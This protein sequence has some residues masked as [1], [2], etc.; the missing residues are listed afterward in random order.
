MK[1][2]HKYPIIQ[3]IIYRAVP[4]A[5][6]LQGLW[7]VSPLLGPAG[8]PAVSETQFCEPPYNGKNI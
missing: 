5:Q 3:Q 1:I 6:F 4:I 2:F 8:L 7:G